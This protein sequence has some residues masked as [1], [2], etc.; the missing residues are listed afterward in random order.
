MS[1]SFFFYD[2][3]TSG[4]SPRSARTMQFAGQRTDMDL[5]PIGEP[6]NCLIKLTPDT[7]PDPDAVLLTGIT[8]QQTLN[9]GYTEA[10][11]LKLF[12]EE[13]VQP[14]TTFLGFNSIRFDDEFMRFL[15]YRN[16]YDAYEWQWKDGC[17]RWDL[18]DLVRMTRALRPDG[19]EW[20]FDSEGKPANR[21]E[22]LSKVNNLE[23]SNAH[24]A[25]SDVIATIE[26][27]KLIKVKQPELFEYLFQHRDKRA[28]KEIVLK[29]EPFVYTSGRYGSEFLHTTV[30]TLLTKHPDQDAAIVYDLRHDPTPFID[31]SVDELV[32]A[33]KF[34]RDPDAL[35]LP[36]K[37]LKYNRCPAL[38]PL[39]V[40]KDQKSQE[41][42]EL[43]LETVSKH[44]SLLQKH[45]ASFAEKIVKAVRQLDKAR[46]TDQIGLV[47]DPLTADERLYDGFIG[48][49]DKNTMSAVRAADATEI[50]QFAE[51]FKD[52][53]LKSLVPLYKARNYPKQL[54][55]EERESWEEFCKLRLLAGGTESRAAKYFNRLQELAADEKLS[56][57]KQFLL[58]ELK[59]YGES[60]LPVDEVH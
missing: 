28:T 51:S 59:L 41:R 50:T 44:L 33:W 18:L 10:E 36:V 16:F 25:L 56:G 26:M 22:Y 3:E 38:A 57:E 7:L 14:N 21:L 34:T 48:D 11:F 35:R 20:P 24:D 32:G 39:G 53:R 58:E 13:V 29:N 17:S 15:H 5:N 8:P 55:G 37:T 2:L 47:D 40:I 9:D 23:H 43:S 45:H 4:F 12:Y 42:I 54:S 49:A 1:A 30:A 6:V 27:A 46:A 31:M 19:I 60:I 52:T